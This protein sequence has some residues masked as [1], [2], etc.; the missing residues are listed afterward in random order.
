M[1]A[2]ELISNLSDKYKWKKDVLNVIQTHPAIDKKKQY[3]FAYEVLSLEP[4]K[5]LNIYD[6]R[7]II[8]NLK[9]KENPKFVKKE[10]KPEQKLVI[11]DL[12]EGLNRNTKW[13]ADAIN[14][15]EKEIEYLKRL[16]IDTLV[17]FVSI[18]KLKES[19]PQYDWN[20]IK[21][22]L[23]RRERWDNSNVSETVKV[24]KEISLK[25]KVDKIL[26]ETKASDRGQEHQLDT[27]TEDQA[28][29]LLTKV[30]SDVVES[31]GKTP[32]EWFKALPDS[33][34]W[35]YKAIWNTDEDEIRDTLSEA[36]IVAFDWGDTPEGP[37]YWVIVHN[38]IIEDEK[39]QLEA[40]QGY[41]TISDFV[42]NPEKD[43]LD[44]MYDTLKNHNFSKL[45]P[46]DIQKAFDKHGVKQAVK[47]SAGKISFKEIDPEFICLMARRM[48]SNKIQFG[49]K[50]EEFNYQKDINTLDLVDATERHLVDLKLLLQEKS[51]ILNPSE[52]E[53]QHIAAVSCNMM[54]IFYAINEK[55]K[56]IGQE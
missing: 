49:G 44:K 23:S 51:P 42:W 8:N 32:K 21:Y 56:A 50:Y 28:Q 20:T 12:L 52:S 35:K 9:H 13:K 47:D 38:E 37:D 24:P 10:S 39:K 30:V 55:A 31:K 14:F 6:W 3:D 4:I 45:S 41:E 19:L 53:L 46:E 18:Q 25:D 33:C 16:N 36:L 5:L 48:N 34:E 40:V 11:F 29:E 43:V 22:N 27:I 54:M 17:K 15:A 26:K 7:G 2:Y 1:T